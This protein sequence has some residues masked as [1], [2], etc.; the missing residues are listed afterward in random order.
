MA[1]SYKID[2]IKSLSI[3]ETQQLLFNVLQK[4]GLEELTAVKDHCITAKQ[5][6]AF[7]PL[8]LLFVIFEER[9]GGMTDAD[10]KSLADTIQALVT[11]YPSTGIH[12][13]SKSPITNGF[14]TKL[15]SNNKTIQ[16]VYVGRDELIAL[17]DDVFPDYWRHDDVELIQY[18][19]DFKKLIEEDTNLRKFSF[20]AD[21]YKQKLNFFIEPQLFSKYEDKKTGTLVRKR[22]NVETLVLSHESLIIDGMNGSG[23]TTVLKRIGIRLIENNGLTKAGK[24]ALP[25]FLTAQEILKANSQIRNLIL[26]KVQTLIGEAGMQELTDKYE[27]HIL[28]D[29]IDELDDKQEDILV[30][31][32]SLCKKYGI[33]YY[34]A[35]RNSEALPL[36]SSATLP[37]YNIARFNLEQIKNFLV[38]FFSNDEEKTSSLL[39]ALRENRIIERLPI[40]PLTLSLITILYE[41]KDLEIPATISDIYDNFNA[42]IVGQAVVSNKI[43]LIDVSFRE[44]ILSV[45]ALR[46]ME[47][48]THEPLTEDEFIQYFVDFFANKSYTIKGGTI[49]DALYYLIHNTGIIFLKDHKYVQFCHNSY[50]EYYTA[51]E[52]F[53]HSRAKEYLLVENFFDANWQNAAIFYAGMSKDMPDFLKLI[54]KKVSGANT[55]SHYFSGIL[56]CG[57]LIQALYTTDNKM[58][59]DIVLEALSMSLKIIN[60]FKK[61]ASDNP[62][63]YKIYKLPILTIVNFV[64]FYESF[65][66]ITLSAPLKMAFNELYE[67]FKSLSPNAPMTEYSSLGF[68]LFELAFTLDS[69]RINDQEGLSLLLDNKRILTDPNLTLLADFSLS[70]LN[71]TNY[72][73]LQ[74]KLRKA[75]T[76]LSAVHKALV[77]TPIAKLRFTPLDTI[78]PQ[79]KVKLVVEG[80]TDA[81]I[82]E[83]AFMV[84]TEGHDPYWT[85]VPG[86]PA[87]G[88]SSASGVRSTLEYSYPL[89]SDED[90][91]I[92]IVDHDAAGLKEYHYLNH[93]FVEI[94]KGCV[95]KHKDANIYILTL[96]IPGEMEHYIQSKQEFNF[97]AIEHYFGHELLEQNKMVSETGLENILSINDGRKT[98]FATVI[99]DDN[100]PEH[101]KYF[102]DLFHK[103]DEITGVS[104]RYVLM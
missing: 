80:K 24:K 53:N 16:F 78:N 67:K 97:F 99:C 18:E 54:L 46:L 8:R 49:E 34:I 85:I 92:G 31:L 4:K 30:E 47:A 91:I 7:S 82:I 19:N 9:L 69:K 48:P 88:K 68:S 61:L 26:S 51:R 11:E 39:D 29:S 27:V 37:V 20:S 14:R 62:E 81:R 22:N 50:M 59:K 74:T 21:K 40:T 28:I 93:D 100:I 96:P 58:R 15:E 72:S 36:S 70:F 33:K 45:Y 77:E 35:T 55:L 75:V 6:A 87:D 101:Y 84:L 94:S 38:S 90:I 102:M 89:V 32:S 10:V 71:K 66:S 79:K 98:T 57:Y 3:D 42:L 17:I 95:K 23:K 104:V 76:S 44:R 12:I 52:I 64:Y 86:G 25:I 5:S 73:E 83:H 13:V 103:I 1:E 43:E 60:I 65:N 41:E 63:M 56:G 2:Y